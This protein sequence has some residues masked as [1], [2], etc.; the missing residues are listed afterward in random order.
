MRLNCR[1]CEKIVDSTA[2]RCPSCG[3][4]D[5]IPLTRSEDHTVVILSLV[6]VCA[7]VAGGFFLFRPDSDP[8]R[9]NA[10]QQAAFDSCASAIRQ[11]DPRAKIPPRPVFSGLISWPTGDDLLFRGQMRSASCTFDERN[12]VTSLSIG[13]QDIGIQAPIEAD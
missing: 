9:L 5:F 1:T 2:E 13:G 4:I 11:A 8:Y 10:S 3:A 12:R 6:I 7:L